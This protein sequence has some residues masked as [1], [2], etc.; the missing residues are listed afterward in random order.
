MDSEPNTT[1][2]NGDAIVESGEATVEDWFGEDLER[3]TEDAERALE[4]AGVD[5]TGAEEIFD[6][7]RR[8]HQSD[9]SD[10]PADERPV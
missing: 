4:L 8:P 10:V 9:L 6:D 1:R 2:V 5:E 3:D 7:V